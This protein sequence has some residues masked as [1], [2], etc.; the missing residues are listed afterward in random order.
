MTVT[1]PNPIAN[2]FNQHRWYAQRQYLSKINDPSSLKVPQP[3]SYEEIIASQQQLTVPNQDIPYNNSPVPAL[4]IQHPSWFI[5]GDGTILDTKTGKTIHD[6]NAKFKAKGYWN[7]PNYSIQRTEQVWGETESIESLLSRCEDP[8][9]TYHDPNLSPESIMYWKKANEES[10]KLQQNMS[11]KQQELMHQ[12]QS[13]Q[14]FPMT[15][16]VEENKQ[17]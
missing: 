12:L 2:P 8:N 5:C 13:E 17:Q 15:K 6:P 14:F 10:L 7:D 4:A 16:L 11:P 9:N 1:N 3:R